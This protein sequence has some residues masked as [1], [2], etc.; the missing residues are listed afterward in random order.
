MKQFRIKLCPRRYE[1][2]IWSSQQYI[3]M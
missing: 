3:Y 1:Y 2:C